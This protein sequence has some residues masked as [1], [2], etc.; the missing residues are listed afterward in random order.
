MA[1]SGTNP[2]LLRLQVNNM[3]GRSSPQDSHPGTPWREDDEHAPLL[4]PGD[5]DRTA[6]NGTAR[7]HNFVSL[8]YCLP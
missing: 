5:V 6:Y 2:H 4:R 8:T 7:S 3:S 1:A